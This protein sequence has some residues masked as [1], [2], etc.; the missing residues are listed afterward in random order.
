MA[1]Q[2]RRMMEGSLFNR[3]SFQ[4]KG[5]FDRS[6]LSIYW[7]GSGRTH[8]VPKYKKYAST[9][10]AENW[11][12]HKKAQILLTIWCRNLILSS[13]RP[14][15]YF[16]RNQGLNIQYS[17]I[18]TIYRFIGLFQPFWSGSTKSTAKPLPPWIVRQVFI[19]C[20]FSLSL[21]RLCAIS[22]AHFNDNRLH[23]GETPFQLLASGNLQQVKKNLPLAPPNEEDDQRKSLLPSEEAKNAMPKPPL[24]RKGGT[25][26]E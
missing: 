2:G 24:P 19:E 18:A 17:L 5:Y 15:Q 4:R 7:L 21:E 3:S 6:H 9:L 20:L 1:D 12:A 10:D 13:F 11:M 16:D 26:H 14:K 23:D 22:T 25:M 8:S